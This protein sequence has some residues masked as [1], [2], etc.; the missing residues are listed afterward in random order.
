[1][2]TLVVVAFDVELGLNPNVQFVLMAIR[3]HSSLNFV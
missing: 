2:I 3:V 1:M